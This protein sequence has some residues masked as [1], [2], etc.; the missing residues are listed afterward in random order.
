MSVAR[1]RGLPLCLGF[2]IYYWPWKGCDT[3]I[4]KTS[5][6]T[7]K[8]NDVLNLY[9]TFSERVMNKFRKTIAGNERKVP[10]LPSEKV[11]QNKEMQ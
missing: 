10:L 2:Y 4:R 8:I 5:H 3:T 11:H 6:T 7:I 9:E 1:T